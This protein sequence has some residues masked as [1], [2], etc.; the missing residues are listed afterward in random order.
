MSRRAGPWRRLRRRWK[1]RPGPVPWLLSLPVRGLLG[2]LGLLPPR[3]ALALGDLLGRLAWLLPRRRRLGRRH[4]A[5]ALPDLSPPERDRILRRSCGHL[6]RGAVEALVLSR[7]RLEDLAVHLEWE[8]GAR[9]ALAELARG[10]AVVVI[11]H[12]G[13]VEA[14]PAA[15]RLLGARPL[16][17]M[18]FPTN[19]YLGRR[20]QR[21]RAR[22]GVEVVDRHGALRRA[23]VALRE[24]RPVVLVADQNAHQK[25]VFVP[26][27]G[28]PAASERAPAALALRTGVPLW[29]AWGVRTR[30]GP[31][32]RVGAEEVRPSAPPE[33]ATPEAL[34]HWMGKVHTALER[35][36]LRHPEQYLW[37]HDRYRTRPPGEA[38]EQA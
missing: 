3:V 23:R 16:V 1:H 29:V 11:G 12:L 4:L 27:F 35:A 24:G 18:R 21:L 5:R 28:H 22:S 8:P 26:W 9:E 33:A 13:C 36:V 15:L 34:R 30:L 32:W 25:P 17:P 38:P 14:V 31:G 19:H 6:G 2:I 20:L 7:R 37:I 10:P